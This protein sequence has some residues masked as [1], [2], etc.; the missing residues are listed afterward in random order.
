MKWKAREGC[1]FL[2]CPSLRVDYLDLV[3]VDT[4][5]NT[6]V[7]HFQQEGV[8][9]TIMTKWICTDALSSYTPRLS[10]EPGNANSGIIIVYHH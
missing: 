6:T 4:S 2:P 9:I 1:C 5:T 3:F 8:L 7:S 10:L